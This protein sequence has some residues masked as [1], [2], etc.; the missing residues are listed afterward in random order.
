MLLTDWWL[1]LLTEIVD[2]R[3]WLWLLTE[4]VDWLVTE[5]VDWLVT[6]IVN[7]RCWLTGDWDCWLK[8]LPGFSLNLMT[9]ICWLGM[10]TEVVDWYSLF[11]SWHILLLD[12]WLLFLTGIVDLNCWLRMLTELFWLIILT[13]DSGRNWYQTIDYME[14]IRWDNSVT[15][16]ICRIYQRNQSR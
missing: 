10:L 1:W 9:R 11:I 14:R 7:W 6:G 8:L 12:C 13:V 4:V 2:W 5:I 15:E 3:C 16:S